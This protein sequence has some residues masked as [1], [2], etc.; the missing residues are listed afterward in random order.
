MKTSVID[1]RD[2]LSVL[3]VVG[4]EERIG[5]V[6]GVESV[7]LNFA[8]ASATVRY[9]ETRLDVAD[10]K[11]AVRQGGYASERASIPEHASEHQPAPNPAVETK[12]ATPPALSPA[13]ET[14]VAEAAAAPVPAASVV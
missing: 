8:A 14:S 9:D 5:K 11:S 7:T 6:P 2:M 3:S 1:V 10:L 12:Q 4:V 13:P